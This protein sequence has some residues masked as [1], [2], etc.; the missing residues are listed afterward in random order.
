MGPIMFARRRNFFFSSRRRHTSLVSDWSSDVCS[1][2]LSGRLRDRRAAVR[3]ITSAITN[4]NGSSSTAVNRRSEERRVGKEY[5]IQR[6]AYHLKKK[7]PS[8]Q[9]TVGIRQ[10]IFDG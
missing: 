1:S 6:A 4:R 10:G 2:D 9:R 7:K 8:E 5:R 3:S